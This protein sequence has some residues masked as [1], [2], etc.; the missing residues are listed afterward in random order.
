MEL[1]A[2]ELVLLRRPAAAPTFVDAALEQIQ[3]EH[4]AY[5]ASLREKGQVVTI[6]PVWDQ[7]DE[8][9][10]GLTF[11]GTG[12]LDGA[13]RLA[14]AD[15]AVGAGRLAIEVMWWC[16]PVGTMVSRGSTMREAE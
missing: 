14:E 6:G 15:P 12:S 10:R 11:Y 2:F 5:H 1:E 7:A 8:S 9:P 13:R 16:C 3:S 4:V